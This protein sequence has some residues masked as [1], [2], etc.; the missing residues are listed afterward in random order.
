MDFTFLWD[1]I[2]IFAQAALGG[3]VIIVS[4]IIILN[5]I[6]YCA[7]GFCKLFCHIILL[8]DSIKNK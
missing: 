8:E 6:K 1:A 3:S 5:I 7:I 2:K 4:S